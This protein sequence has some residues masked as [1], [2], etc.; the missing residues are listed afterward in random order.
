MSASTKKTAAVAALL[1][2]V[3]ESLGLELVDVCVRP[4]GGRLVVRLLVD[5][6]GG[7]TVGECAALSRE[8]GPHLDVADLFPGRYALEVSSPGVQRPLKSARDFERFRGERVVVRTRELTDGRKT[9]RGENQGVDADGNLVVDD[10]ETRRRH[11]ISVAN[12]REASLD[13]ELRF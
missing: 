8:A 7:V 9:F 4:E 5:R 13:P 2:P 6:P 11:V 12:I 10:R 3:A 1:T